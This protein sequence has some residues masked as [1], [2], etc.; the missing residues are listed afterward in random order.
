MCRPSGGCPCVPGV[1]H[2]AAT[3][4]APPGRAQDADQRTGF[5]I[6][7]A[8]QDRRKCGVVTWHAMQRREAERPTSMPSM[9]LLDPRKLKLLRSENNAEIKNDLMMYV[10][11]QSPWF[12]D[13]RSRL[14][15]YRKR[16]GP[17]PAYP[18]E[19]VDAVERLVD[20]LIRASLD[21]SHVR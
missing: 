8:C 14:Q 9:G 10:L 6:A 11:L 18:S 16:G 1:S 15:D 19:R 17:A 7:D 20:D 13:Y 4:Q 12:N 21:P 2:D 5:D 3:K